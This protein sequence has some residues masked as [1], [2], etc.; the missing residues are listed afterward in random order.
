MASHAVWREAF[1]FNVPENLTD[2]EA[3]P[4]MCGGATVFAPLALYGVKPTDTVGVIGVG[5]LGHLSIQFAAKMGCD[6]VVFSG[7]DA[8]KEEA[9]RLG[10]KYFYATKG[11]KEIKSEVKI[12]H[13]LVTTS[14]LPGKLL[15][16]TKQIPDQPTDYGFTYRLVPLSPRPGSSSYHLSSLRH[17]G[18]RSHAAVHAPPRKRHHYPRHCGCASSY[19]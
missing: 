10:A 3:A 8:K 14:A 17:R 1:L 13:L 15:R 7:T 4:L 6:V 2:E 16:T 12:D 18:R 11:A 9:M 5:G 19:S